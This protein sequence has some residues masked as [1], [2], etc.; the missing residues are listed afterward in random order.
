MV[1]ARRVVRVIEATLDSRQGLS[2]LQAPELGLTARQQLGFFALHLR[3]GVVN[4][5]VLVYPRLFLIF[6]TNRV[7]Q[8][9][10]RL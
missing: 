2:G 5:H 4:A 10:L 9:G 7:V 3:R 8:N 1:H 6:F